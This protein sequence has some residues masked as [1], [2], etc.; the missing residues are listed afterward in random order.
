MYDNRV[1]WSSDAKEFFAAVGTAQNPPK[2]CQDGRNPYTPNK[3]ALLP[4][5]TGFYQIKVCAYDSSNPDRISTEKSIS[6]SIQF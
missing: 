1:Q 6:C 5:E 4:A 3:E 2:S